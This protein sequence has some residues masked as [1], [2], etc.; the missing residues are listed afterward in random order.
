MTIKQILIPLV[1]CITYAERFKMLA[2]KMRTVVHHISCLCIK[3]QKI[4]FSTLGRNLCS[5]METP[6]MKTDTFLLYRQAKGKALFSQSGD[7]H[8]LLAGTDAH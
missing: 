8:V 6:T 7:N 2:R 5:D 1:L 3:R 4:V